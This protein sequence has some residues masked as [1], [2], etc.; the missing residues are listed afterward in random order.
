MDFSPF[1]QKEITKFM[2]LAAKEGVKEVASIISLPVP[3]RSPGSAIVFTE[4]DKYV[5]TTHNRPL[6]V[7]ASLNGVELKRAFMDNGSSL[8]IMPLEVFCHSGLPDEKLIRKPTEIA[9]FGSN[10]RR[11]EGHVTTELAI[12]KFK[13]SVK[14]H[15][16][17]SDT[18]YYL[19]M[20]R[21]WM[22][23][24]R[25]VPSSYHQCMKRF[26]NGKQVMAQRSFRPELELQINEEVQ[27]LLQAGFIKPIQHSTW[28]VNVVPI[29]KKNGKIRVCVDFKDLN[30][31]C[32]KDNFPLPIID[33]L[34]DST[35]GH[36]MFSFMDG[37]NGYNHIRM[38]QCDAEKMAFCTLMGN[39]HFTVMHFSLKNA[40]F[41]Y[42][43]VMTAIFH[44]ML[45]K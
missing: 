21:A 40:G 3:Q 27:R 43:R 1:A 16:I 28:L 39:F 35:A 6:Y 17:D 5:P 36:E 23:K 31:A 30:K 11:I 2:W 34:I 9:G 45:Q 19:L 33:N 29:K 4:E 42:Q 25:I 13:G 37:Y 44:D 18:S 14:F 22:H 38:A 15:V 7:T 32:P 24:F 26:W 8:N 41:T 12:G 10:I 20:G